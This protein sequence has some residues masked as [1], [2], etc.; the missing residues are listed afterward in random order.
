MLNMS[1]YG[2]HDM[3]IVLEEGEQL[4]LEYLL[5]GCVEFTLL[6]LSLPIP[7]ERVEGETFRLRLARRTLQ[8][9]FKKTSTLDFLS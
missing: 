3:K 7:D 2:G 4:L 6:L 9:A 8:R 1:V 5:P